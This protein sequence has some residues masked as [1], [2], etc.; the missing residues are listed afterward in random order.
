MEELWADSRPAGMLKGHCAASSKDTPAGSGTSEAGRSAGAA[1]LAGS[2]NAASSSRA[3][4]VK[5]EKCQ[6]CGLD[7]HA[8]CPYVEV[9]MVLGRQLHAS[10][11]ELA[12]AA[13][14][15]RV[16][17]FT[18]TTS[19]LSLPMSSF[20]FVKIPGNGSCLFIAMAV[21]QGYQKVGIVPST[22]GMENWGELNRGR[23]VEEANKLLQGNVAVCTCAC[24]LLLCI[25]TQLC[26]Q[27][28]AT[29]RYVSSILCRGV[30]VAV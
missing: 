28:C 17:S 24:V 13:V 14:T 30:L 12:T 3:P 5:Q 25:L 16:A 21:A 20:K 23:Y 6:F 19:K 10:R 18:P 22:L 15:A 26:V 9:V 8:P 2:N 27:T 4:P 11:T 1:K 7:Y 29:L